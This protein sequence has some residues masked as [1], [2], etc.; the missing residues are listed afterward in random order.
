MRN[1]LDLTNRVA[2]V[3]GSTSGIGRALAV[4]LAEHGA[5]V[6]PTGRR[7]DRIAEVCRDIEAVGMCTFVSCCVVGA[8][9]T[10][11]TYDDVYLLRGY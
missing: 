6:V 3:I 8:R 9:P 1:C 5:N 7:P 10:F 11:L 2:V 4:G